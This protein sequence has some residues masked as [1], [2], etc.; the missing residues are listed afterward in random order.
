M[1]I[2]LV[3]DEPDGRDSLARLLTLDG[4]DVWPAAD[5]KQMREECGRHEFD[6]VLLDWIVPGGSGV[7]NLSFLTA[8][9][10][11]PKVIVLTALSMEFVPSGAVAVLVKPVTLDTLE[12]AIREAKP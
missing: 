9:P 2:L 7:E 8:L 12:A 3:E 4:N 6:V 5:A 10:S 1:R 11:P